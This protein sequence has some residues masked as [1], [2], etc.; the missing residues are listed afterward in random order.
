MSDGLQGGGI[1]QHRKGV[2]SMTPEGLRV[3]STEGAAATAGHKHRQQLPAGPPT[4]GGK[5]L[6]PFPGTQVR[7]GQTPSLAPVI[8]HHL[9]LQ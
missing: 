6:C 4:N 1:F 2:S 8:T 5:N 9:P 7:Q 3:A